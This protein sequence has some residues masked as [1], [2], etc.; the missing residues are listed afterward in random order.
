MKKKTT[1]NQLRGV[2]CKAVI[3]IKNHSS[4]LDA[5]YTAYRA[6]TGEGEEWQEDICSGVKG[7]SGFCWID[8]EGGREGGGGQWE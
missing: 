6:S 3:S 4:Q 7:D 1:A 2:P 5:S 8:E